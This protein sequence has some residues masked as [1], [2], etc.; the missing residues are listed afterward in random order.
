[1]QT[2][3]RR[4][5]EVAAHRELDRD[6][7]E[8]AEVSKL[9]ALAGGKTTGEALAAAALAKS[10]REQG[11]TGK[12][13]GR[14]KT[15]IPKYAESVEEHLS[16]EDKSLRFALSAHAVRGLAAMLAEGE[17]ETVIAGEKRLDA[18][19]AMVV[20]S[21]PAGDAGAKKAGK[22]KGKKGRG[23]AREAKPG[24]HAQNVEFSVLENVEDVAFT[25]R[26]VVQLHILLAIR[27]AV[28]D[29][30]Y[31]Y[32]WGEMSAEMFRRRRTLEQCQAALAEGGASVLQDGAFLETEFSAVESDFINE[33]L[34]GDKAMRE[35]FSRMC[36]FVRTYAAGVGDWGGAASSDEEF[37]AGRRETKRSARKNKQRPNAARSP[38]T[39]Q[40]H[41]QPS[42]RDTEG[43]RA[44]VLRAAP[45]VRGAQCASR[46]RIPLRAQ[47]SGAL[48]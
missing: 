20:P 23:G 16:L 30:P 42:Q 18:G 29:A 19:Q 47:R 12:E 17:Q 1:M 34:G 21:A 45:V 24:Q 3:F 10:R 31:N 15:I 8:K 6:A 32:L 14:G 26:D 46:C 27:G 7:W 13:G 35:K 5:R 4:S 41:A 40:Q 39:H 33:K 38:R 28:E 9:I 36:D 2:L 48:R 44:A 22:K 11:S 25:S 43:H 37:P